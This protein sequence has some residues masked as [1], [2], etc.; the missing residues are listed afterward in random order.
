M[1]RIGLLIVAVLLT[2][3]TFA[4]QRYDVDFTQSRVVKATGKTTEMRGHLTFDGVDHLTMEYTEPEGEYF[5]IEGNMVKMNLYGKK[6]ELNTDKVKMVKL[7]RETLLNCLSGNWGQAA[8]DNNAEASVDEA[9]GFSFIVLTVTGKVPRGGYS[10]VELTYRKED[11]ALIKMVLEE[12]IGIV[13][14]Y[15]MK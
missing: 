8:V 11:G 4:Q 10:S 13:N 12:S 6:A 7:Q 9:G 3:A 1:K 2:V 15:E 14:T 5:Y